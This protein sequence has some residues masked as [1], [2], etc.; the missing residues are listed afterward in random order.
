MDATTVGIGVTVAA[1]LLVTVAVLFA[2]SRLFRKVE[3]AVCRT[4]VAESASRSALRARASAR[5]CL[6]PPTRS[7]TCSSW[8][9]CVARS[10]PDRPPAGPS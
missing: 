3:Q 10:P 6:R 7:P 5:V 9:N 4:R 8:P 1:V 2:V